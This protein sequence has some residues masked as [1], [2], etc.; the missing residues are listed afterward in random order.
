MNFKSWFPEL[1]WDYGDPFARGLMLVSVV[2][3]VVYFKSKGWLD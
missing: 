1:G 2:V 3:P